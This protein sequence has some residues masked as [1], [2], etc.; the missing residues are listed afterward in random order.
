MKQPGWVSGSPGV[1]GLRSKH[2]LR[3]QDLTAAHHLADMLAVWK[4]ADDIDLFESGWTF[5]HFYPIFRD[6]TGRAWKAG[7]R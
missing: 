3:L 4:E 2:A 5:D 6:P 7:S 1:R